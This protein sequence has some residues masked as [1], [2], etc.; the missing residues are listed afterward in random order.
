[1]D[2]RP[3]VSV[4]SGDRPSPTGSHRLR[5]PASRP[6][7]GAQ[8]LPAWPITSMFVLFPL[9]WLN[10]LSSFAT[11]IFGAVCLFLM[12]VRG[13]I[14]LPRTWWWWLSYL[15]WTLATVVMIDSGGRL[16]G[17]VVRWTGLFGAC[18]MALYAYNARERLTRHRLVVALTWMFGWIV[19]G[20]YLGL[21]RPHGRIKTL[22]LEVVPAKLQNNSYVLEL[23]SPR[24][25]EVQNPWGARTPFVRPSAPFPYTNGWGDAFVLLLPAVLALIII[26]R[27]RGRL[28]LLGLV[29]AS[30][31]PALATLNRGV[32]LGVGTVL[33]YLGVRYLYRVRLG[34]VLRAGFVLMLVLVFVVQS[35]AVDRITHRTTVSSTTSDRADL[36]QETLERTKDSPWFGYGA[37]RPSQTLQVSVGTQG[38]VWYVMF[39]HGFV[40]LALFLG[41]V[42]GLAW[43]TRR[44]RGLIPLLLHSVL[45][46]VSV[47]LLV[48]GQDGFHLSI[49]MICGMVLMNASAR[50]ARPPRG[51]PGP[52]GGGGVPDP[53][54]P[55]AQP[56]GAEPPGTDRRVAGLPANGL[57][58]AGLPPTDLPASGLP[59]I[60]I[61]TTGPSRPGSP[62]RTEVEGPGSEEPGPAPSGAPSP[63]GSPPGAGGPPSGGSG[64]SGTSRPAGPRHKV[65]RG[66]ARSGRGS[67]AP[68]NGAPDGDGPGPGGRGEGGPDGKGGGNGGKDG[69]GAMDWFGTGDGRVPTAGDTWY[70]DRAASPGRA[71][72]GP[73]IPSARSPDGS[74]RPTGTNRG[75]G[76]DA[77]TDRP[78][79]EEK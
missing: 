5:G 47:L 14:E 31:P 62:R 24:F 21:L 32:F 37:P 54:P 7:L 13:R 30:I 8:A 35:G 73:R 42:W 75:D 17:F 48:Y 25:A 28:M 34:H 58:A 23:L 1:M 76:K 71:A 60:G 36:Y 65:E 70:P 15:I 49:P 57:P 53:S 77:R 29:V 12:V 11:Q 55:G 79:E 78:Q 27:R 26:S 4:P 39:S 40:G 46:A 2:A 19:A 10:G 67:A 33:A 52:P 72:A 56:P 69:T 20:G 66:P 6:E 18:M 41:A 59:T 61:L 68:G 45:V 16:I 43:S 74:G 51:D 64:T 50:G 9:I 44:V 63:D 38:Q 22:A 3:A